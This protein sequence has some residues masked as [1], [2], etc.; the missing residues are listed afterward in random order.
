[1]SFI[2]CVLSNSS[3]LN[4][5]FLNS[6]N[7]NLNIAGFQVINNSFYNDKSDFII[8]CL[9]YLSFY[10]EIDNITFIN[11]T[12]NIPIMRN[13]RNNN[14]ITTIKISN[15]NA[16]LNN[17]SSNI[18]EN[19]LFSFNNVENI[20]LMNFSLIKNDNNNDLLQI[21]SVNSLK[22]TTF[23]ANE[24]ISRNL[25]NIEKVLYFILNFFSCFSNN[26]KH[27]E[28][29]SNNIQYGSCLKI[30]TLQ[31]VQILNTQVKNSYSFNNI[32]GILI[33]NSKAYGFLL[34][35]NCTFINNIVNFTAK[36]NILGCAL[37][38][39]SISNLNLTNIYYK[40]NYAISGGSILVFN[41]QKESEVNMKNSLIED[42][43]SAKKSLLI[44]FAGTNL[45]ISQC[46]F[47]GNQQFS[48]FSSVS[49]Y[50]MILVNGFARRFNVVNTNIIE[51]IASDG[52]YF[53][54][55]K[56]KL[57]I[58]FDNVKMLYN[59]G[60]L[61]VGFNAQFETKNREISLKNSFFASNSVTSGG[62]FIYMFVYSTI[63]RFKFSLSNS[64]IINNLS[65][66]KS[67]GLA[68]LWV[69]C[70]NFTFAMDN[71]SLISNDFPSIY[72]QRA[73][74]SV[75]GV[76]G[77]NEIIF[78]NSVISENKA[79]NMFFGFFQAF[80]LLINTT[81]ENNQINGKEPFILARLS[82]LETI[83][84]SF[85]GNI[86]KFSIF[87]IL[88][89]YYINFSNLVVIKNI[90]YESFMNLKNT[91]EIYFDDSLIE[92]N[93]F[94]ENFPIIYLSTIQNLVIKFNNF[95]NN[96]GYF[97]SIIEMLGVLSANLSQNEF[98]KHINNGNIF[99]F[100]IFNSYFILKNLSIN[101]NTSVIKNSLMKFQD[102]QIEIE[103]LRLDFS[104]SLF[105]FDVLICLRNNVTIKNSVFSNLSQEPDY[106][107]IFSERTNLI[108]ESC[109]FQ[110]LN[111]VFVLS[112][113]YFNLTFSLFQNI[114]SSSST[115]NLEKNYKSFIFST[116]FQNI[117]TKSSTFEA[118]N[119][120]ESIMFENSKFFNVS[121][122][123]GGAISISTGQ[124]IINYCK[125][126]NNFAQR[127][128]ALYFFCLIKD[129][130][131]CNFSVF[132]NEF[133]ENTA[134]IDGG[135][136][137]FQYVE[138]LENNNSY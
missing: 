99:I 17:I 90:I 122:Y 61:C 32:P 89:S 103:E 108:V 16:S 21:S 106:Y 98:I 68:V 14:L 63:V 37:S 87:M 57:T 52:L 3:L 95:T 120:F 77:L 114:I 80:G 15:M 82:N 20:E 49:S 28:N 18:I 97:T 135:A 125:F 31:N 134:I 91:Q 118:K 79:I 115:I 127:G 53:L 117:L 86:M 112:Q 75:F 73:F 30:S 43:F 101:V 24:N 133:I 67:F 81:F 85:I 42:N 45:T 35:E 109:F 102:S 83:N 12:L 104:N 119:S 96:N 10:N 40:N 93:T 129:E 33:S 70:N 58:S 50:T 25:I 126:Y 64:T 66:P 105:Y 4:V 60:S 94:S 137:K 136:F 1:M 71:S 130:K 5:I 76:K 123:N 13:N 47:I 88:D 113:S 55:E 132:S 72:A 26:K 56:K 65:G 124:I 44:E 46:S 110:Y 116:N 121:G 23:F 54:Y 27:S 74:I 51:N 36:T 29:N 128:G 19:S 100:N 6:W 9:I 39:N 84:C 107:L 138:P 48:L 7:S 59:N 22:I 2:D 41:S 34:F 69:Y 38:I 8:N 131:L 78:S 11:N 92:N 62:N 111:N